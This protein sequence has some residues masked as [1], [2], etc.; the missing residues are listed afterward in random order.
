MGKLLIDCANGV[1]GLALRKLRIYIGDSLTIEPLNTE[2]TVLGTLNNQC[3][4]D[5]VKTNQ[6]LPPSLS[7]LLKP[8][9]RACSLDGDADRLIYFYLDE[10]C[11]FCLL[12][13]DKIAALAAI[14]VLDLVK[15]A[16]LESKLDV[17][18][19]QTAYANGSSTRYLSE[20]GQLF[21]LRIAL[22]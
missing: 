18:V 3:G 9:Q 8:G 20:V 19:V 7:G 4:A 6:K 22:I 15:M 1:G 17:G 5:F 12:D 21:S 14:F 13:G 11:R 16:G 2:T 10:N